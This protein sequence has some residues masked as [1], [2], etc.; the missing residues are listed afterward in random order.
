[1]LGSNVI[2][3]SDARKACL[4]KIAHLKRELMQVIEE[5]DILKKQRTSP[6]MC[7]DVRVHADAYLGVSRDG[8]VSGVPGESEWLLCLATATVRSG[9]HPSQ[10]LR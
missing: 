8:Y 1:M 2:P 4:T 3:G 6:G 5:R 7:G 10:R 9:V